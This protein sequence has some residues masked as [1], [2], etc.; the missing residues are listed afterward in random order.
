MRELI[1]HGRV[2]RLSCA[3]KS[4]EGCGN[5]PAVDVAGQAAVQ[6]APTEAAA[7]EAGSLEAAGVEHPAPSDQALFQKPV[8]AVLAL[9]KPLS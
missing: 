2:D 7:C 5:D 6:G 4:Q 1:S 8:L 9:L 3:V